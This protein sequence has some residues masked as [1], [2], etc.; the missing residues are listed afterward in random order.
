MGFDKTQDSYQ[1][2]RDILAQRSDAV[3]AWVGA[4]LSL[5]ASLPSWQQL[6]DLLAQSLERSAEKITDTSEHKIALDFVEQA[7]TLRN[8]WD[9]FAL[10]QDRMGQEE[11]RAA[12]R[13]ALRGGE[14]ATVPKKRK[15]K[16]GMLNEWAAVCFDV[17]RAIRSV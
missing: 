2:F 10:L 11:Y 3:V 5:P 6:R 16:T 12:I 14:T 7:R 4:G 1:D 8:L 17:T 15:E 13:R 9:A